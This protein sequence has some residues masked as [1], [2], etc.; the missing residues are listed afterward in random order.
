MRWTLMM[1]ALAF[2][3]EDA[4]AA[5]R[6]EGL[7]METTAEGRARMEALAQ[8]GPQAV[9]DLVSQLVA[10]GSGN[11]AS[12]RRALHGLAITAC[13][14]GREE[15]RTMVEDVFV[16]ALGSKAAPPVKDFILKQLQ[17]VGTDACV[18][19]VGRFL[20]DEDL[21][22]PATQ[23]LVAIGSP[24]ALARIRRA[25]KK[26]KGDRCVPLIMA[27]GALAD[28]E[29]VQVVLKK[30]GSE[31]RDIRLVALYALA[32]S[33]DVS[34]GAAF[35]DALLSDDAYERA[36]ALSCTC[37]WIRRLAEKGD[38]DKAT[39]A[40]RDLQATWGP[41]DSHFACTA[42]TLLVDVQGQGALGEVMAALDS[43]D[44]EV[45]ERA[46]DLLAG[47]S[48]QEVND[49]L[50]Q[51]LKDAEAPTRARIVEILGRRGEAKVFPV[52][53]ESVRDGDVGVRLAA[54]P[55]V[56]RMDPS[57]ALPH[58]L[59]ILEAQE[60]AEVQ[61]VKDAIVAIPGQ[62][63]QASLAEAIRAS[64]SP[65]LKVAL[66]DVL[67]RRDAQGYLAT[68]VACAEDKTSGDV[69]R[70]AAKALRN[71]GGPSEI[72][73]MLRLLEDDG[74]RQEAETSSAALCG[75]IAEDS[76]R[77][78]L[79][80][81][82]MATAS[83]PAQC[84]MIRI[85]GKN[86]DPKALNVVKSLLQE[87][88]AEIRD[89]AIRS[90][91]DWPNALAA[92]DLFGLATSASDET[93]R[94]LCLRGAI[95][96][97]GLPGDRSPQDTVAMYQRAM[98]LAT[99][100]EEMKMGLGGLGEMA[101]SGALVEVSRCLGREDLAQEAISATMKIGKALLKIDRIAATQAM[102][103]VLDA[104]KDEGLRK[105]AQDLLKQVESFADFVTAWQVS[106]PYASE[107][108]KCED[109]FDQVFPPE[110]ADG[111]QAQWRVVTVG[112]DAHPMFLE[113][114][115]V[116]Q[117]KENSVAYL[118]TRV[119]ASEAQDAVLQIG[120]DDGVKVWVNGAQVHAVNGPRGCKM[121]EDQ[122][123]IKLSSDWTDLMLKVIQCDGSW[124]ACAEIVAA[125][126]G[127]VKG[128]EIN[129]MPSVA[130]STP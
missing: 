62:E 91:A 80:I 128:L 106:G 117:G 89:V 88:N 16:E 94:I 59:K 54:I 96:V 100:A 58:L 63:V 87:E 84:S 116:F 118:K 109:L 120:T 31:D 74:V 81:Q 70:G 73:L 75:K 27:L 34:V 43:Q 121:G 13:G 101:F 37:L 21:Q 86:G 52:L 25:A 66:M 103:T 119:R 3:A 72:P 83:I 115:N 79:V 45:V 50:A 126:E 113:I 67:V 12:V 29:S 49:K 98:A 95:R 111:Q 2:L 104:S 20:L 69:R 41:K 42:L 122:I 124:R 56:A 9:R 114:G 123:P 48:G 97:A 108:K 10:P 17:I 129:P 44:A 51:R 18:E 61:A 40:I 57:R 77:S 112:S 130:I 93:H 78:D 28:E 15:M 35:K 24:D 60:G 82:A 125:G 23:T 90:L 8:E 32:N 1:C 92:N 68:V 38:R 47:M 26:A 22:E 30:S 19:A 85:L 33:G 36:E 71:L 14:E 6:I 64:A 39:E 99:R 107:G 105:E 7:P 102:K 55:V 110:I 65:A 46:C 4:P 5:D 76:A 127:V 53:L 11:D